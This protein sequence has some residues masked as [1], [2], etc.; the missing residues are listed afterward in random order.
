MLCRVQ[1]T[2]IADHCLRN[3]ALDKPIKFVLEIKLQ[4]NAIAIYEL[5]RRQDVGID[6]CQIK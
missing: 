6:N 5:I 3:V 1:T 4:R 2:Q